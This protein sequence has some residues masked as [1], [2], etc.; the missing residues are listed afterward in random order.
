MTKTNCDFIGGIELYDFSIG[1]D[2]TVKIFIDDP[3]TYFKFIE[4]VDDDIKDVYT[5]PL[6]YGQSAY[7]LALGGQH[8]DVFKFKMDSF[9]SGTLGTTAIVAIIIF[10]LIF[11]SII[12]YVS[13]ERINHIIFKFY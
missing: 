11:L 8:N 4:E 1:N 7:V 12:G 2:V 6:D 9:E 10:S 5:I 3:N 13:I